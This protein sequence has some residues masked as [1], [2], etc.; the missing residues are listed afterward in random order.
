[1]NPILKSVKAA[2][3]SFSP[4]KSLVESFIRFDFKIGDARENLMQACFSPI[5]SWTMF[6]LM[7]IIAFDPFKATWSLSHLLSPDNSFFLYLLDGRSQTMLV[8]FLAAFVIEWIIRREYLILFV[9]CYFLGRFELHTNLAVSALLGVLLSRICY[10]GWASLDLTEDAKKIWSRLHQVQGA[11]W[12]IVALASL[13]ALDFLQANQLFQRDGLLTRFNFF[14]AVY[15]LYQ[16]LSMIGSM[17]WGH[18]YFHAQKDPSHL[19]THYSSAQFILRFP[20]GEQLV[21]EL[22]KRVKEQLQK[23]NQHAEEYELLRQQS[24]GLANFPLSK[25]INSE[26]TYLREASVRLDKI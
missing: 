23:H 9:L 11:S 19:V 1:M 21:Y 6:V 5:A 20:L 4:H 2:L 17:I 7:V 25:V 26:L 24:P 13:W 15:A 8:F 12:L 10:Q 22:K 3:L 14:V 16:A 18:F